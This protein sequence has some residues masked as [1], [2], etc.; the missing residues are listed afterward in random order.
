MD[1]EDLG[2][3]KY[4]YY[5]DWGMEEDECGR[6]VYWDDVEDLLYELIVLR[7]K[8]AEIEKWG[9]LTKAQKD[10]IENG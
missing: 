3:K 10:M 2:I 8:M 4:S 7:N 1:I 9:F 5:G 6:Y